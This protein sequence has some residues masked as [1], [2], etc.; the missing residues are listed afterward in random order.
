ML[1]KRQNKEEE[2]EE[3]EDKAGE[4]PDRPGIIAADVANGMRSM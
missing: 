1:Q 2:V 3:K 4:M